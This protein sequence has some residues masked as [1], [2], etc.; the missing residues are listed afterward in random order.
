MVLILMWQTFPLR[1]GLVGTLFKEFKYTF[2]VILI[3][4]G[5][6]WVYQGLT[7]FERG[8]KLNLVIVQTSAFS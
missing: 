3:F 6:R 7:A 5:K 4:I 1:Y 2:I 8:I